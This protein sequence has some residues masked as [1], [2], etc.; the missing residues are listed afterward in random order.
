[1]KKGGSEKTMPVTFELAP[2][3]KTKVD[4]FA[5]AAGIKPEEFC[6]IVIENWVTGGGLIEV[7][8]KKGDMQRIALDWPM[9]FMILMKDA[10]GIKR[11]DKVKGVYS[12]S[13]MDAEY[14]LEK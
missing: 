7:G 12:E 13:A 1:M 14:V 5:K 11:I 8:R 9:G 10:K 4:E 3:V 2:P 6:K